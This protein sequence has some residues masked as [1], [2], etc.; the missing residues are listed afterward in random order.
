MPNRPFP[1]RP[2]LEHSNYTDPENTFHLVLRAF[3]DTYP[4][5]GKRGELVWTTLL[6]ERERD[7]IA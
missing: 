4:F 5:S 2:R 1:K 6:R 3:V 7:C